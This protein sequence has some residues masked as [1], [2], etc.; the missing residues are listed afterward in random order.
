MSFSDPVIV[1]KVRMRVFYIGCNYSSYPSSFKIGDKD[2][3]GST[4]HCLQL[5]VVVLMEDKIRL[6]ASGIIF[7]VSLAYADPFNPAQRTT[8]NI[9]T[10]TLY[11]LFHDT[12]ANKK[13]TRWVVQAQ[14]RQMRQ[15]QRLNM[16]RVIIIIG[17]GFAK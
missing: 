14:Q 12:T 1:M 2:S 16:S 13:T 17:P 11:N 3:W 9:H 4:A 5:S 15:L 8:D 6:W 7:G 10:S